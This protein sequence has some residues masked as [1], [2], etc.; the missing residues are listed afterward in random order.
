LEGFRFERSQ[1]QFAKLDNT[2]G[3]LKVS[4]HQSLAIVDDGTYEVGTV[5]F[6][7]TVLLLRDHVLLTTRLTASDWT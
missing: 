2:P 3:H 4:S 7:I 1:D 5:N 6:L